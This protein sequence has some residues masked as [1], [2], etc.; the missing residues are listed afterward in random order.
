MKF[1]EKANEI[2]Q[3]IYEEMKDEP[4]AVGSED[5]KIVEL[6]GEQYEIFVRAFWEKSSFFDYSVK[7]ITIDYYEHDSCIR[8]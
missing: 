5:T 3:E 1:T 6:E 7:G 8:F 4:C 2:A